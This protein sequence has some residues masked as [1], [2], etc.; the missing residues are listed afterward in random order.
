MIGTSGEPLHDGQEP[1]RIY[2]RTPSAHRPGIFDVM[3]SST[4]AFVK[5]YSIQVFVSS[6]LKDKYIY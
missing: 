2:A 1:V 4:A 5:L 3:S 6:I